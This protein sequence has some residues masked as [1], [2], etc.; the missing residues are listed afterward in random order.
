[1]DGPEVA[2]I[3]NRGAL[4]TR[5]DVASYLHVTPE[6]AGAFMDSTG[7]SIRR[8]RRLY[9]FESDLIESLE[10]ARGDGES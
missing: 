8:M 10:R 3:K 1:M 5:D 2:L 7:M 6:S 9:I 4:L